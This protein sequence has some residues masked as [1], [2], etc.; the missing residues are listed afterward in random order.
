MRREPE[1]D[2]MLEAMSRIALG[3][4]CVGSPRETFDKL[5]RGLADDAWR[6]ALEARA[7]AITT[8]ADRKR[9]NQAKN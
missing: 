9:E 2:L 1:V 8:A 5:M 6:T 3:V 7:R 4:M